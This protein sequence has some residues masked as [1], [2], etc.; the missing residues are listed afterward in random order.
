MSSKAD[1]LSKYYDDDG[2]EGGFSSKGRSNKKSNKKR[3][4]TEKHKKK[5]KHSKLAGVLEVHDE[6]EI[7]AG[8]IPDKAG[9]DDA[10]EYSEEE[11]EPLVVDNFEP[12]VEKGGGNSS[13]SIEE[14]S[15][16]SESESPR[17][18]RRY[19]SDS[20]T[21]S[22][23]S[24]TDF[25]RRRSSCS[26]SN[27]DG[28]SEQNNGKR[29]TR[30]DSDSSE[31]QEDKDGSRER[32][33]SGH[34]AGLQQAQEFSRA[35]KTI[36]AKRK[37]EAQVMVDDHG[38]GDTVYRDE[39]GR[40]N[41]PTDDNR[42]NLDQ[43]AKERMVQQQKFYLN[44]GKRQQK[45][46]EMLMQEQEQ[47]KHSSFARSVQD[48]DL[49]NIRKNALREGDPMASYQSQ[50]QEPTGTHTGISKKQR[51]FYKGPP[52]PPNR[53]QIKPGYRWDGVHRGNGFEEK[54][55]A[56]QA[57]AKRQQEEAYRWSSADM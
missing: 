47:L 20:D 30:Y 14:K 52:A 35:E 22:D 45:Q 21:D 7:I 28:T 15:S 4:K 44:Q 5:N 26:S 16:S 6:E 48:T 31:N 1:Y 56:S 42:Q 18:R 46:Q 40:R 36:Q 50:Q 32:M 43:A 23:R 51:P 41:A 10:G 57:G 8:A 12:E 37:K 38:V 53:F 9:K 49:E 13:S 3:T 17:R 27:T 24:S 33:S 54:L 29:K 34:V 55:L 25:R 2:G 11:D 39:Q 19:D